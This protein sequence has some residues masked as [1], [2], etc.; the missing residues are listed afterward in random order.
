MARKRRIMDLRGKDKRLKGRDQR[1][2]SKQ[3]LENSGV[4]RKSER[5]KLGW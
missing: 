3:F 2:E 5:R 1:M 4:M